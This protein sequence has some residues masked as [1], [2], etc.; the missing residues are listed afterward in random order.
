MTFD[1]KQFRNAL[2]QFATGVAIVTT[3]VDGN[4]LGSTISS[5]NS[6]SLDPPLVLFSL[7]RSSL[8]IAQWRAAPAYCINILGE[9]QSD[10][11]N[12][13]A[14]AGGEKW[15]SVE[16]VR[17]ANGCPIFPGYTALF[18]CVPFAVHDGG[19]HDIF[20]AR[21]TAFDVAA[22]TPPPLVFYAGKYRALK[23]VDTAAPP[24]EDNMW[25]HGW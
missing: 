18:E 12:R 3:V 22:P 11:S 15:S 4:R 7:A 16:D 13:F 24:P 8:G 1:Q 25:L 23:P 9:A 5:F 19:D 20:V 14:R 6:V 2:G 17:A 10:L 21:V